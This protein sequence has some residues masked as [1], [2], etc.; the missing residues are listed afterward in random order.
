MH[1]SQGLP[2]I[3]LKDPAAGQAGTIS[4]FPSMM[5]RHGLIAGATGTGKTISL[6]VM[7]EAFSSMGVPVFMSDVKGDLGGIGHPGGTSTKVRER[8]S[9][10]NLKD[11]EAQGFP[12]CFWDIF[13]EQGHPLRTTVSEMGPLLLSRMLNLNEI[14]SGVLSLVF[15]LADDNGL[16]LLD[17]KDLRALLD[18]A[19]RNRQQFTTTY[20]NISPSS[21]GAI[22]RGLL[23][24]DEQGGDR[25]FGEPALKITDLMRTDA[26]GR[27]VVNILAADRLMQSPRL[28]STFLLWLLSELFE[29]LPEA[30]DVEKPRL[31]FFFDEAHLL[32]NEAPGPLLEKI[33]QMVRLIRSKG[34]G[35]YFITQNPLDVPETVLGQLGNRIQHALR[36]FTPRDQKAVR[37]A[38]STCRQNP[39]LDGEKVRTE[40]GVGE[41]LDSFL[42]EKGV[43]GS[44]ERALVVPPQSRI[45]A[46]T[47]E[48]RSRMIGESVVSGIYDNEIDRESAFEVLQQRVNTRQTPPPDVLPEPPLFRFAGEGSNQPAAKRRKSTREPEDP[49]LGFLNDVARTASRSATRKISNDL[50]RQLVRGLLGGLFGGRG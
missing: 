39:A 16:L 4:F 43:P 36:A 30:G 7:A 12:V 5:N 18:F 15:R 49:L 31:V 27:G 13:G 25:F 45:G 24:L 33:E 19:A 11:Y 3:P 29:E 20:G 28:Y 40:R 17:L 23:M 50:G 38:A 9:L 32:F 2:L 47:A 8:V 35:I 21:I 14:Q 37:A 44:V 42:D 34:V 1:T 46:V 6:Q 26:R 22:Q 41:A 10:F 48:E